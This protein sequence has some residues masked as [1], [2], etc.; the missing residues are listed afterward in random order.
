VVTALSDGRL[1]CGTFETSQNGRLV[2]L[3][4]DGT[5][6]AELASGFGTTDIG[7]PAR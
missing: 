4:T 6:I 1:L 2:L 3:Q 5:Y 7:F